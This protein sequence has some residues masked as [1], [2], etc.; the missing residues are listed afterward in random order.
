M[1]WRLR[2]VQKSVM[3]VQSCC[4]AHYTRVLIKPIVFWRSS[5]R[6]RRGSVR[7][8]VVAYAPYCGHLDANAALTWVG[9]EAKNATHVQL[10]T[11]KVKIFTM[12]STLS[13]VMLGLRAENTLRDGRSRVWA[14]ATACQQMGSILFI[15]CFHPKLE[16]YFIFWFCTENL[17]ESV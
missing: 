3:H 15:K 7:S 14:C 8:L 12:S 1:Q 10:V 6:H 13:Q 2:N 16:N 9:S 5:C 4:F 17:K 11:V